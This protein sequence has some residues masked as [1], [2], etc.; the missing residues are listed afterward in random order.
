MYAH[1]CTGHIAQAARA[2]GHKCVPGSRKSV[3]TVSHA[4]DAARPCF[5]SAATAALS[6]GAAEARMLEARHVCRRGGRSRSGPAAGKVR[7][8]NAGAK[9]ASSRLQKSVPTRV[10]SPGVTL[11]Y[12]WGIVP[13]SPTLTAC[14]WRGANHT[15]GPADGGARNAVV[16]AADHTAA[17]PPLKT[18]IDEH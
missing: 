9:K 3:T 14:F 12:V 7:W 6:T 18:T 13:A 5:S 4:S 2:R 11:R 10:H 15:S 1:Y 17:A 8:R 16:H